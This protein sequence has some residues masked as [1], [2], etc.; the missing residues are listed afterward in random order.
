VDAH[1]HV[2]LI[3]DLPLDNRH[4]VLVVHQRAEPD[5]PEVPELRG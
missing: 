3:L 2:L 5:H 4:V 1:E